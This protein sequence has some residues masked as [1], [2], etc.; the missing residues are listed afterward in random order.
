MPVTAVEIAGEV[1][2]VSGTCPLITF[3]LQGSTVYTTT[4]TTI[5]KGPCRDVRTGAEVRVEGFL[6]SDGR[7]RADVITIEDD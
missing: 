6:M 2:A 3:A 7:V 4:A 5:R 1:G